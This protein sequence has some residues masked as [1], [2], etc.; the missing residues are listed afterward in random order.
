LAKRR[1]DFGLVRGIRR[2]ILRRDQPVH[3]RDGDC[4]QDRRQV[5]AD[6]NALAQLHM[7]VLALTFRQALKQPVV[8]MHQPFRPARSLSDHG[9]VVA[10]IR[11]NL[12]GEAAHRAALELL[13]GAY[14]ERAG[15]EHIGR[16]MVFGLRDMRGLDFRVV[17]VAQHWSSPSLVGSRT[18]GEK[19]IISRHR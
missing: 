3:A 4:V 1:Q 13:A 10:P 5:Y 17:V 9:V 2:G 14:A 11:V 18:Y 6:R 8:E 19:V 16:E 7:E 15:A 12:V